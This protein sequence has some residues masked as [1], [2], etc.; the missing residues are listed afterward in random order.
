VRVLGW[1]WIVGLLAACSGGVTPVARDGVASLDAVPVAGTPVQ[2]SVTDYFTG[3]ALKTAAL[4]IDGHAQPGHGPVFSDQLASGVHSVVIAAPGYATYENAVSVPTGTPRRSVELFALPAAVRS[5]IALVNRDRKANGAGPVQVDNG[6]TIAAFD[7][8]SDMVAKKYFA[9]FDPNG[10][11]PTTRS[12]LLGSMLPGWE[13]IAYGYSSYQAAELAFMSE[14]ASL[15]NKS[16]KDCSADW[17]DAGHYCNIVMPQHNRV[18]VAIVGTFYDEEF[19]NYY[20]MYDT[21]AISPEPKLNGFATLSITSLDGRLAA[22]DAGVGTMPEPESIPIATLDKDPTCSSL[23]PPG[24]IWWPQNDAGTA[25]PI[26]LT[27]GSNQIYWPILSPAANEQTFAAFW[28]GGTRLPSTY[29]A[30]PKSE[31]IATVLRARMVPNPRAMLPYGLTNCAS[32][33][34][35]SSSEYPRC[36]SDAIKRATV[37][38]KSRVRA[39]LAFAVT[40]LGTRVPRRPSHVSQPSA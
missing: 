25:D 1:I 13:N 39:G 31:S 17:D 8:A 34:P 15:P 35:S 9:H 2:W 29:R 37:S 28:A 22:Y 10:F 16:P 5:W 33:V 21:S 27:F 30:V 26:H 32:T 20:G 14:K 19:S 36:D 7:H 40:P 11:S 3:K 23:C 4:T 6:L 18:G 12:L 38:C 24:D